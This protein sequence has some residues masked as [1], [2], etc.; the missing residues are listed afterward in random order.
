[1]NRQEAL[2]LHSPLRNFLQY[3][4][5]LVTRCGSS[6]LKVDGELVPEL[7]WR[8]A[9]AA[10]AAAPPGC[11]AGGVDKVPT[12][13]TWFWSLCPLLYRGFSAVLVAFRG[14]L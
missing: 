14:I 3:G 7:G 1:M 5:S 13:L 10:G 11:G 12:R 2:K 9:R 6:D 4:G 8:G